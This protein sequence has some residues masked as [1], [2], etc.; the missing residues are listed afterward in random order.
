MEGAFR[1][2]GV[3]EGLE[4][5]KEVLGDPELI[6]TCRV[7]YLLL[8]VARVLGLGF[9][10]PKFPESGFRAWTVGLRARGRKALEQLGF[11][12]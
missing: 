6:P 8:R 1:N 7:P 2:R 4:L 3:L 5:Q 11:R 10:G 9:A 12:V